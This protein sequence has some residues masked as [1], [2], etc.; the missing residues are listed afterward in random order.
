MAFQSDPDQIVFRVHIAAPPD[1]VYDMIA[2]AEGRR[3]FWAESAIETDGVVAFVFPDGTTHPSRIVD[4]QRPH[5]F[6]LEY[7]GSTVVFEIVATDKSETDVVVRNAG[8]AAHERTEVIAGWVSVL[9]QLKAAA[10]YRVDLR[11]HSR[12]RNWSTGYAEN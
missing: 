12:E 10:Q 5:R 3:R 9:M 1:A 6:S 11:N 4:R 8:V 2:T 7:F